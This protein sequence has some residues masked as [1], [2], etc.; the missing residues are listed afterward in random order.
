MPDAFEQSPASSGTLQRLK[1]DKQAVDD[2]TD[3]ISLD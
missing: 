3:T 2:F 1:A